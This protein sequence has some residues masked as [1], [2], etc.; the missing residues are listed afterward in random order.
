MTTGPP[1]APGVTV[2]IVSA[3]PGSTASVGIAGGAIGVAVTWGDVLDVP[4]AF[5]AV[6][7]NVYNVLLAK[8]VI[9]HDVAGVV[10]VQVKAPGS[11]VTV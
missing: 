7:L 4:E 1:P 11:A 8:P 10:T 2:I 9:V 3:S 6:V 5:V